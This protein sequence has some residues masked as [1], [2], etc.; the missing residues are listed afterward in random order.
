M[1][2][3]EAYHENRHED[4]HE[5]RYRDPSR[6]HSARATELSR[7]Q[8]IEIRALRKYTSWTYEEIVAATPYTYR[9]VQRALRGPLL[10]QKAKPQPSRYKATD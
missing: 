4:R 6:D 7:D 3:N 10:P 9:Q 5:D 2:A 8:R 1:S